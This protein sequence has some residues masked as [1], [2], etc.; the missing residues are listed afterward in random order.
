[1]RTMGGSSHA[2]AIA[3]LALGAVHGGIRDR[4]EGCGAGHGA[5]LAHD[6][7]AEARRQRD[8]GVAER[9][10]CALDTAAKSLGELGRLGPDDAP[11]EH[12]ELFAPVARGDV[13]GANLPS[14]RCAERS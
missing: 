10:R 13:F 3:A 2:D 6:H 12:D 1:M 8:G 7:R 14:Q 9:D 11:R 4:D 5:R